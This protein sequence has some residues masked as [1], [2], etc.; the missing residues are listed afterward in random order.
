[1]VSLVI[2]DSFL[3]SGVWHTENG[4]PCLKSIVRVPFAQSLTKILYN[5]V[6]LNSTISGSIRKAT[7]THPFDGQAVVVGLP[8]DFVNHSSIE[9]EPNLSQDDY[10]DIMLWLEEKKDKPENQ[11]VSIF[12]QIYFPNEANVHVCSVS[13]VLIRTI[14]LSIQELGGNPEWMGPA[15]SLYLDGSGMSEAAMIQKF[16]N[17]YAFYKVQ[18]NRFDMGMISFIGGAPKIISTTDIEGEITLAALG[19][20][21][22]DL[23]DIPV[24]CPQKL[25]RQATGEWDRSDFNASVPFDGID[26]SNKNI[27]GLPQY[28]ANILT[29]LIKSNCTDHSFNFFNEPGITEFFFTEVI[30]DKPKK[31]PAESKQKIKPIIRKKKLSK[32]KKNTESA[33]GVTLSLLLILFLFIGLNYIKL[34]DDLNKPIFGNNNEFSIER[35]GITRKTNDI[36]KGNA[37]KILLKQSKVISSV[38]LNLLTQTDLDRYNSLT[39]TKSFISLEYVSGVNPNIENILTMNPTSFSV[40]AAGED[41]TVFLWYYSFDLTEEKGAITEGTLTKNDLMTQLDTILVDYSLKYFEQVFRENQIY[42]PLL[43]WVRNKADILE[44]SA[45]LSNVGDDILLR[46]FTLMNEMGGAKP[47]AG[48][49]VSLLED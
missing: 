42:N 40:D 34:Q 29:Q 17:R 23:D 16:G 33:F 9:T 1:M 48:F 18:N 19:L 36:T 5:E 2:S 6:E 13:Q 31:E 38:L 25:G 24:F 28:E 8:D 32:K 20:I 43:I 15:S 26:T 4:S 21:K 10:R 7:E 3:L 14:K 39:I 49:Y 41:S 44:T 30:K 27:D 46:K 45:I 37:H 22:S 47:R 35:S 11:K 12:G